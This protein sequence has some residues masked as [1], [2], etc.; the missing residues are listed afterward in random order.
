MFETFLYLRDVSPARKLTDKQSNLPCLH[1]QVNSV[2]LVMPQ[3]KTDN[4][5][6]DASQQSEHLC[7]E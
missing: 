6:S 2:L 4:C 1:M 3:I 7:N 5:T